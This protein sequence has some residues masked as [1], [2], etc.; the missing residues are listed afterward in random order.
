MLR[1]RAAI[2]LLIGVLW[3]GR[4]EIFKLCWV[5]V[6]SD[7][8]G[9]T[10]QVRK[11]GELD[12]KPSFICDISQNNFLC[13]IQS[14]NDPTTLLNVMTN[15]P[16]FPFSS[17]ISQEHFENRQLVVW[18]YFL[19]PFLWFI[20]RK[21]SSTCSCLRNNFNFLSETF[22]DVA[23]HFFFGGE[24]GRGRG[25]RGGGGMITAGKKPRVNVILR[26]TNKA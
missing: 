21:Y 1:I 19:A 11:Q 3:M 6:L 10:K 5:K 13:Y 16:W 23:R 15:C 4:G 20:P 14:N 24:R 2:F 26:Q 9:L 8:W 17:W 12:N 22:F 25:V 7:R 18:N